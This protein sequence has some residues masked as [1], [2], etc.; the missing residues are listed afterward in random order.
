MCLCVCLRVCVCVCVCLCVCASVCGSVRVSVCVCL[1]VCVSARVCARVSVCVCLSVWESVSVCVCACL[2]L[3]VCEC[4]CVCPCVRQ[5]ATMRVC[6]RSASLRLCG[7]VALWPRVFA[8]LRCVFARFCFCMCC[9][10]CLCACLCVCLAL[11]LCFCA[12][13]CVC[14]CHTP[15][16]ECHNKPGTGANEARN[17]APAL[18]EN[19]V[20]L[21]SS[22]EPTQTSS[23]R[24]PKHDARSSMKEHIGS[25]AILSCECLAEKT[26]KVSFGCLC[27]RFD[28]HSGDP[29]P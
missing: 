2:C 3:C 21:D 18:D 25:I 1:C 29:D 27:G 28:C 13:V 11:S 4:V 6:A 20:S 16:V 26:T 8:S 5:R 14:T 23:A 12:R 22:S 7:G 19:L 15:D 10:A 24:V 9:C 17:K